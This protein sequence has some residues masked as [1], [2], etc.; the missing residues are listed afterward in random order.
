M[1]IEHA[2]WPAVVDALLARL[3][4]TSGFQGPT[5]TTTAVRVYDGPEV[6]NYGDMLTSYLVVGLPADGITSGADSGSFGQ[7]PGPMAA[8][9]PMDETGVVH[10]RAVAQTGDVDS[11]AT[12]D[13]AFALLA[14]VEDT[15][16][17]PLD[18]PTLGLV[19]GRMVARLAEGNLPVRQFLASGSVCEID[20][21]VIY[22]TRIN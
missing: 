11:K 5:G 14:A 1:T 6:N 12:R 21:D 7:K 18:G 3:R 10:C 17:V 22:G 9:R 4:A 8:N 16:R 15:L 2:R 19:T 20:F 13:T